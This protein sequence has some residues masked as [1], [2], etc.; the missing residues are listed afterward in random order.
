MRRQPTLILILT[1][2]FWMFGA[3]WAVPGNA[4]EAA[5]LRA[6]TPSRAATGGELH[7][8]IEGGQPS[9]V[10]A[11]RA[12]VSTIAVDLAGVRAD[13]PARTGQWAASPLKGYRL[14]EYKDSG[15]QPILRLELTVEPGR[16]FKVLQDASGVRV[17]LGDTAQG[18]PL[19]L[20]D[21]P[22]E[23]ARPTTVVPARQS[24]T[25]D[26]TSRVSGISIRMGAAGDVIIEV[27]T[28][29][30]S[31]FEVFQL[32][33]P[34]RLVVDLEGAQNV[35]T[36]RLYEA[37]SPL[38]KSVRLGQFRAADPSVVRVV[39]DLKGNPSFDVHAY[40]GGVRIHLKPRGMSALASSRAGVEDKAVPESRKPMTPAR[41]DENRPKEKL[42]Q[43]TP[44][45]VPTTK[46]GS[47]LA[48]LTSPS[49][50]GSLEGRAQSRLPEAAP[51]TEAI[52]AASEPAPA[53]PEEEREI[54][55]V[56]QLPP[57]KL[58]PQAVSSQ[59]TSP[60]E[61]EEKTIQAL[62][63]PVAAALTAEEKGPVP[64]AAE[65]PTETREGPQAQTAQ[66]APAF[67]ISSALPGASGSA[68][69]AAAPRVEPPAPAAAQAPS[70]VPV[71]VPAAAAYL[72]AQGQA[73]AMESEAPRYTGEP[74]SLN[75]K[76]VDLK[77]FFRLIH[78]ISGLNIIVDPNVTGSVT[79]VL[80]SVPWDQALDIVLANNR[81]GKTLVG[82]VLRIARLETLTAEQEAEVKLAQAR[83]EAQPLV[84]VF[85]PVNYAKASTI[86]T[87]L[88]AWPGGGALSRRGTA[89]VDERT[90]TLIISD[91]QKQIPVIES[92]IT[93][94]DTKA[95]QVSIE[96][97]IV[98]ASADFVRNFSAALNAG[99]VN[100]SGST[101]T[102]AS[103]GPAGSAGT[104]VPPGQIL[105]TP[106][107][108][109]GFGS[110]AVTN[111]GARYFINAAIAAA[112]TRAQ[113]KT[114]SRPS[115]V[116]QNN[117]PGTVQQGTQIPI[118]TTINNTI[119]ITYVSAALTLRVTPQV[120][121]DGHIFL[122]IQ[123]TNA[124][125]GAV[126]TGAG[127]SI[128][129]QQATTQVLVPDGGTVV[130]GGVTVTTRS[131]SVTQVPLIGSIP[132]LGH[133]FKS[134][135][136]QDADQE[137]LFFVTPRVLP[138]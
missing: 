64:E 75:L 125:P 118:Q 107:A 69:V 54:S 102:G 113:A 33:N 96:A 38:L 17:L 58:A 80:D 73:E 6:L 20:A 68:E 48:T 117:V 51:V 123:V 115:I 111:V 56:V 50:S 41:T 19:P 7:L 133:L 39:A 49:P 82:N 77:D 21:R 37:E 15:G 61:P 55:E 57:E 45:Q 137:L 95:K 42:A 120:T 53:P 92:I 18:L 65:P 135:V 129:T 8:R 87:M 63:E 132:L 97:R 114:I 78:E 138:S 70:T 24:Q 104:E 62:T 32:D 59:V 72:A 126:L 99:W 52:H 28:S 88:K 1:M 103:T 71:M 47:N 131:R 130:F 35:L 23:A 119:S 10:R 34:R 110:V 124:A 81:L 74:I 94:L 44:E 66:A 89:L 98:R 26:G 25:S 27:A 105:L 84:T 9:G 30:P 12:D 134:S 106:A 85:R 40:S 3:A 43:A 121:D 14:L 136:T 11:F 127:P 31:P 13:G 122:D 29:R 2:T 5:T 16:D 91:I 93:K 100:Q 22:R 83:E 4:E 79:L 46:E 101:V 36:Q 60:T 109:T 108:A 112:E 86:A 128:N 76:D 90:N 116:T 67:D